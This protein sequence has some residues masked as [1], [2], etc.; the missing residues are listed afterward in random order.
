MGKAAFPFNVSSSGEEHPAG[1]HGDDVAGA[2]PGP[3]PCLLGQRPFDAAS[4]RQLGLLDQHPALSIYLLVRSSLL[5]L[6]VSVPLDRFALFFWTA[7]LRVE[8]TSLAR[9]LDAF[10]LHPELLRHA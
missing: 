8:T 5:Q 6:G 4:A 1:L 2:A 7:N 10:H 9:L 3:C